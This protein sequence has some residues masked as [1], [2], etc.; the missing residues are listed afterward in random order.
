M[1]R[2]GAHETMVMGKHRS[3]V[4][5]SV[6]AL[7]F[8]ISAQAQERLSLYCANLEEQCR[9]I[10]G[11]F[12]R[13]TGIQVAMIRKSS[14]E[15][16][17]QVKA[18]A[19]NPRGDVWWGGPS[20]IHAQAAADGLLEAYRSPAIEELHPWFRR[21]AERTGFVTTG[22]YLGAV[23]VGYRRDLLAQK[24]L[25]A[26]RCW[27]DLVDPRYRGEIQIADPWSS[28]TSYTF[29]AA[30]L[31]RLGEEKGFAYLKALHANIN[32]YAKSGSA[33]AKA[34]ALGETAIAIAFVHGMTPKM[35]DNA[36]VDTV[37]PCE[38]SGHE[39]IG[40]SI[41]KGQKNLDA[42]K[43]FVDFSLSAEAQ[44]GNA[45]LGIAAIPSNPGAP[46]AVGTPD[47]AALKLPENPS[48]KYASPDERAR[49]L[50]KFDA[51]VRAAAR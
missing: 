15:F 23:G 44:A 3:T 19:T 30:T 36:P 26:P 29:L 22:V 43:R 24:N 13:K 20:E 16:Y 50:K 17:A 5:A 45:T 48:D 34:L 46:V 2:I 32:Q 41:I 10:A 38:G 9:L 25:P 39:V 27:S 37:L 40:V 1:A 35:L 7:G 47:I 12:E 42:A 51:E 6:L 33:P 21:Q 18:E 49:I 4:L 14:G 11:A 31:E 28:G 8:A